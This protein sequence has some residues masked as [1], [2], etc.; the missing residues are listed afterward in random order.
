M[1]PSLMNQRCARLCLLLLVLVV[2]LLP[3][4]VDSGVAGTAYA[5]RPGE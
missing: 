1:K 2:R 4:Q 5:L 3:L